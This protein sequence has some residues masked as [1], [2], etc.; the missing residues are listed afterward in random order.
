MGGLEVYRGSISMFS[1]GLGRVSDAVLTS[2]DHCYRIFRL[3][4]AG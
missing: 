3:R 4:F 1:G 2:S